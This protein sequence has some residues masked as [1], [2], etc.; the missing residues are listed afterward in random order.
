[1]RVATATTSGPKRQFEVEA[2]ARPDPSGGADARVAVEIDPDHHFQ[3]IAGFGASFTDAS[4]F[5]IDKELDAAQRQRAMELLFDPEVGIGLSMIRNPMGASDFARTVYSYDDLPAGETDPGLRRFTIDHD[6]ESI[7]PL[8]RLAGEYNPRLQVFATP[9]SPPGWMKDSGTMIG[10][11]LLPQWYASY[12]AYFVRFIEAYRD[13]GVVIAAVTPQNEPL[14]VPDTYPGARMT[15]EQQL[16]FVR[17]HLRPALRAAGLGTKVLGFD[18]NWDLSHYP[19]WLLEHGAREFDGV[20]WHWYGGEPAAQSALASDYPGHEVHVTEASGGEWIPE[21]RPAFGN[22]MRTGIEIMRNGA[23]SFILWNLAL[24]LDNGPVVPGFGRSECRGLLRVDRQARTFEPTVDYTGLAH[25]SKYI[26][27]RA[28]RVNSTEPAPV[29]SLAAVNPDGS[30]AVVL[31]ND[32]GSPVDCVV[33]ASRRFDWPVGLSPSA[34][35]TL[36]FTDWC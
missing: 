30:L 14:Y 20:A 32:S 9:W 2:D 28:V 33:K 1:M 17:D 22:L 12:A 3:E 26:R 7:L 23:Q 13:A 24:D 27:P 18:H 25:L 36:C 8:T 35:V 5:L 16:E 10:G 4:A 31:F 21:F 6:R 15:P 11:R 29:R 19:R 34:A